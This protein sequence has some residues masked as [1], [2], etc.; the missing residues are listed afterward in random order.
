MFFRSRRHEPADENPRVADIS[1]A[2]TDEATP[3]QTRQLMEWRRSAQRVTRAWNAWLAAERRDRG[4]RYRAFVAALADEER[5]AAEVERM[6]DARRSGAVRHYRPIRATADWARGEARTL[7]HTSARIST[8][9]A[10]SGGRPRAAWPLW[11]RWNDELGAAIYAR[12]RGGG[13][14]ARARPTGRWPSRATASSSSSRTSS[15]R[16]HSPRHTRR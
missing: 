10:G 6:I 11:A 5:A 13:D 16:A 15:R 7:G 1:D 4:M 12:G 9:S 3:R 8:G 14:A 2:G